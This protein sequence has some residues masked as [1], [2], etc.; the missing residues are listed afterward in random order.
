MKFMLAEIRGIQRG[1]TTL[2][3]MTLP[4][5]LS[6]RIGKL[7]NVCNDEAIAI[8]EAR[9]KLVKQYSVENSE[10]PGEFIVATENDVVFRTKFTKFLEEEID[11]DVTPISLS[12]LGD[13]KITPL[14]L[15]GLSKII[16]DDK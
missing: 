14:D 8:E 13:I 11:I 4:I 10:K 6:Y 9:I 5:K 12:E 16:V 7:I 15:A 1:L 3:Q 2:S